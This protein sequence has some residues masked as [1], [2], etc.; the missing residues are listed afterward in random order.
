M[1]GLGEFWK[2]F[3]GLGID[4]AIIVTL[5]V[6]IGMMYKM[7]MSLLKSKD[8]AQAALLHALDNSTAAQRN[9]AVVLS[10]IESRLGIPPQGPAL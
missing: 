1:G 2:I 5:L 10:R 4:G 3:Q 6:V 9:V 7:N 8:K